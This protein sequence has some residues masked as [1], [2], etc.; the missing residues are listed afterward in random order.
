MDIANG[1]IAHALAT[2][3]ISLD[4]RNLGLTSLPDSICQLTCLQHLNVIDNQ[5]TALPCHNGEL[6]YYTQRV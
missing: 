2:S 4:L 1:R 3:A 5:L 6:C